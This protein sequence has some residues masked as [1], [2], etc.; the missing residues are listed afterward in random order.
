MNIALYKHT[1]NWP[2]YKYKVSLSCIASSLHGGLH[3]C[4]IAVQINRIP[5]ELREPLV[6]SYEDPTEEYLMVAY[7]LNV[8]RFRQTKG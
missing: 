8:N 6:R 4:G 2:G 3:T 7:T 5:S 1:W